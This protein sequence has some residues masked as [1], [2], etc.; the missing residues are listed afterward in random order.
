MQFKAILE[1]FPSEP[2]W[3]FNFTQPSTAMAIEYLERVML[4]S[5]AV[6]VSHFVTLW[7]LD[8]DVHVG[9]FALS[10]PQV[11]RTDMAEAL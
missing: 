6:K 8:N 10:R 4:A 7:D 5:H 1:S 9:R 3:E 2:R 11:I